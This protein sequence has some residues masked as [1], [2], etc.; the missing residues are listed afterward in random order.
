MVIEDHLGMPLMAGN[1][2]LVGPNLPMLGPRFPSMSEVYSLALRR[3]VFEVGEQLNLLSKL[4]SGIYGYVSGPQ[5]ETKTEIRCLHMLGIDAVGMSTVPE[6]VIAK[7]AGLHVLG[8][9]MI[10]NCIDHQ[11]EH[12]NLKVQ[13]L[14][15]QKKKQAGSL[16]KSETNKDEDPI[17]LNG[18]VKTVTHEEV[19]KAGIDFAD[20]MLKLIKEVILQLPENLIS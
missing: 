14:Q 20:D 18:T 8:V 11:R 15:N 4:H 13:A 17:K 12:P 5:Y 9:S 19:L 6:V 1:N 7:H 2:P 16:S 3:C 10:T